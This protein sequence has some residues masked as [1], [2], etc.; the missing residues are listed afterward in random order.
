MPFVGSLCAILYYE[1]VYVRIFAD[2]GDEEE[3][4]VEEIRDET[5]QS[6][7]NDM[8]EDKNEKNSEEDDN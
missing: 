5:I 6:S 8:E 2:D 3:A 1:C 7:E 4:N